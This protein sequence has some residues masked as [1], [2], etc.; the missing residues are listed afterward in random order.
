MYYT[1]FSSL[2]KEILGTIFSYLDYEDLKNSFKVCKHWNSTIKAPTIWNTIHPL[3]DRQFAHKNNAINYTTHKNWQQGNYVSK[4]EIETRYKY[5]VSRSG[6]H[7][8]SVM[9]GAAKIFNNYLILYAHSLNYSFSLW[10]LCTGKPIQ[11][12]QEPFDNKNHNTPI[13]FQIN[14]PYIAV[15][16]TAK[17][18]K[19]WEVGKKKRL[20]VFKASKECYKVN[21]N[22]RFVV[23]S[24]SPQ[25][26]KCYTFI[27]DRHSTKCIEKIESKTFHL[28]DNCV[29]LAIIS[30]NNSLEKI[31]VKWVRWY[32]PQ[33]M[34]IIKEFECLDSSNLLYKIEFDKGFL[35]YTQI[36]ANS[37]NANLTSRVFYPN[38]K[39]AFSG[40]LITSHFDCPTHISRSWLFKIENQSFTISSRSMNL[41]KLDKIDKRIYDLETGSLINSYVFENT[42]TPQGFSLFGDCFDTDE[43]FLILN[44]HQGSCTIFNFCPLPLANTA[45]QG[46]NAYIKKIGVKSL[47]AIKNLINQL[48]AA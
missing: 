31:E 13:S 38:G 19:I 33:T 40:Q 20:S 10:N 30:Q 37:L 45:L 5:K 48:K 1:N 22:H 25:A 36:K 18:I 43:N 9:Y 34:T 44:S 17:N 8:H 21:F 16:D 7:T 29:D 27:F 4:Q 2:P 23:A 24:S 11:Y 47:A 26:K 32:A 3:L 28:N 39:Q 6:G 12:F 14:F 42:E 46:K 15:G 35:C 41:N